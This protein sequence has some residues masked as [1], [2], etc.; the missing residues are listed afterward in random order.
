MKQ[1]QAMVYYQTGND[2]L[3]KREYVKAIISF[4]KA[5]G[6]AP[7]YFKAYSN[8]GVAYK[9]AGLFKEAEN[10]FNQALK[11]KP[12]SAVVFNNLGNVYTSINKLDQ[13]QFC[14]ERALVLYPGY[15]N[16]LY[17]LSQVLY[18]KGETKKALDLRVK[19]QHSKLGKRSLN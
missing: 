8:L 14:Y 17:N 3:K 11:I 4:K 9:N 2:L 5:I 16:A 15:A 12:K 7:Y 18:F 10:I 1:Q 6:L 13:A 19:M